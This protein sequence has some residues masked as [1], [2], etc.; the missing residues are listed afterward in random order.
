MAE[1]TKTQ[2]QTVFKRLRGLPTNKVCFDCGA[3]NPSWASITYGVF[4][5]IDCSGTH[6]SLG[7]HLS[8]IRST[9]LDSNWTWFQIRCMQVGGNANASTYFQQHGCG[10]MDAHSKYESR[11]AQG[12]RERIRTQ[13]A[14]ALRRNGTELWIDGT[15][16]ATPIS[17][18][19]TELDT[20]FFAEHTQVELN[21]HGDGLLGMGSDLGRGAALGTQMEKVTEK[22]DDGATERVPSVDHLGTSPKK[23]TLDTKSLIIGKKKGVVAK[24]GIGGRKGGLGAQK[25]SGDAFTEH[26]KRAQAVDKQQQQQ[27]QQEQQEPTMVSSLRLA[28]KALEMDRQ[29]E[30]ETMDLVKGKKKEELERLGMGL[31][32]RSVISHSVLMD[33]QIIEQEGSMNG[34]G[35][36]S[37]S[38]DDSY[39]AGPPTYRDNP[40]SMGESERWGSEEKTDSS[41]AF[42]DSEETILPMVHPMDRTSTRRKPE[43]EFAFAPASDDAQKKFATAKAISSDMYF[44]KDDYKDYEMQARLEN[45]SGNSA[46]SSA[47]LFGEKKPDQ[48]LA[49]GSVLP[50]APDMGQMRQGVKLVAGRLSVLASGIASSIQDR[51]GS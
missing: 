39:S 28:Y 11:A 36:R 32:K 49:F 43:H 14:T 19:R 48:G 38:Y 15:G 21:M 50:A 41:W 2:I 5:C 4:L 16:S 1:P 24:K 26:E 10:V 29:K 44:G 31:G 37:E 3:K 6:R 42:V 47:D 13:A 25:V 20:D 22:A 23:A 35:K 46:I 34:R 51:Y 12:Y 18:V 7:V 27:Q 17:P 45:L 40:F 33:M 8:F 9:E 30:K